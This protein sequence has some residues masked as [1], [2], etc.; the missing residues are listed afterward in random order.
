MKV[1]K[2]ALISYIRRNPR[3]K[4]ADLRVEFGHGMLAHNFQAILYGLEKSGAIKSDT[5]NKRTKLWV[6][7]EDRLEEIKNEWHGE[8]VPPRQYNLMRAPPLIAPQMQCVRNGADAHA[9]IPSRTGSDRIAYV[10]PT[11]MC[12][13]LK[14][15]MQ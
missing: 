14:G 5:P 11:H 6:V 4:T 3:I 7:D 12:S 1:D 8:I 2:D 10:R 9:A 13:S 15:G